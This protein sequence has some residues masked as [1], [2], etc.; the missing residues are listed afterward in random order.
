MLARSELIKLLTL[1]L[2]G[3]PSLH[4]ML[5]SI[6]NR[7]LTGICSPSCRFAPS[8]SGPLEIHPVLAGVWRALITDWRLSGCCFWPWRALEK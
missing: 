2:P 4:Q 7:M 6:T 3:Y 1:S 8:H 5:Q